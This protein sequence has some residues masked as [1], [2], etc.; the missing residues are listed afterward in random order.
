MKHPEKGKAYSLSVI[1]GLVAAFCMAFLTWRIL[2]SVSD[3]PRSA[4]E[5]TTVPET[6]SAEVQASTEIPKNRE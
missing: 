3:V 2:L 1:L 4:E 5:E 6:Y